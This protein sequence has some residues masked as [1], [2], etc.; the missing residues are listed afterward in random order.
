ML[1]KAVSDLYF[2]VA[3]LANTSKHMLID[4]IDEQDVPLA[5]TLTLKRLNK[6]TGEL[7][8][9][10]DRKKELEGVIEWILRN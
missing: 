10:R 7:S 4:K 9:L 1:T 3:E 2:R 6:M 8:S 5:I